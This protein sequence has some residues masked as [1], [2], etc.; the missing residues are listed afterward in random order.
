MPFF[1]I[2][3]SHDSTSIHEFSNVY[4][5]ELPLSGAFPKI[6]DRIWFV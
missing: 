5:H 2:S 6:N 1:L 3:A 4:S